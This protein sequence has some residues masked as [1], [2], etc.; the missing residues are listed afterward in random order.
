M[1]TSQIVEITVGR[2][3]LIYYEGFLFDKVYIYFNKQSYKN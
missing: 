2:A 3:T 1:H